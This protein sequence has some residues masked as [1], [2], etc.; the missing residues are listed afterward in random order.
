MATTVVAAGKIETA[1]SKGTTIPEGWAGSKNGEPIT[2]PSQ[3]YAEEGGALLPLGGTPRMGSY[4]GFGL[5]VVV[6]I[7]CSILSGSPAIP[8]LLSEPNSEGRGNHFFGAL[9]IDGFIPITEFRNAMDGMIR[10]Y[11]GLPKTPGIERIYLAGEIEQETEKQRRSNG[12]P[13][14]PTVLASLEELAIELNIKYDL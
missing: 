2:E 13:L 11:H 10:V 4:K 6:D 1:L 9:R 3:Y 5:S 12:I 8:R 7:L 14:E